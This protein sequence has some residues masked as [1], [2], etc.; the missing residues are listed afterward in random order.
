MTWLLNGVVGSALAILLW[1]PTGA[2]RSSLPLGPGPIPPAEQDPPAGD[3]GDGGVS[4]RIREADD[5]TPYEGAYRSPYRLALT[6]PREELLFDEHE[7]RGSAAHQSSIPKEEWYSD[8][9]RARW[10]VTFPRC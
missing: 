10:K 1:T 6:H 4:E 5:A 3:S 7:L 9:V 8:E 2:W